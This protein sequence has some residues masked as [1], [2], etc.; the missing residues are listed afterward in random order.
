M[1]FGSA[2]LSPAKDSNLDACA[3]ESILASENGSALVQDE[4]KVH[5]IQRNRERVT[6]RATLREQP[7]RE[8]IQ[9]CQHLNVVEAGQECSTR[10]RYQDVADR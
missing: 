3:A 1:R 8:E 4:L 7:H 6:E 9:R 5:D 10:S 2:E